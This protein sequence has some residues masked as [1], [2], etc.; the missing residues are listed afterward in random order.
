MKKAYILLIV[1]LLVVTAAFISAKIYINKLEARDTEIRLD[2]RHQGLVDSLHLVYERMNEQKTVDLRRAYDSLQIE[3]EQLLYA[4][5]SQLDLYL[6]DQM[7]S[8]NDAE[9]PSI[10]TVAEVTGDEYEEV[11]AVDSAYIKPIEYEVYIAY[12][13]RILNLPGD[14]SDYERRVAVR[15]VKSRLEDKYDLSGEELKKLLV[16]L[17]TR[18]EHSS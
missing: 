10:D 3:S 6:F 14:L 16:K 12:L 15:E 1:I 2:I 4:L 11:E 13:E 8:D 18:D 17:R 5:E 9:E 7:E